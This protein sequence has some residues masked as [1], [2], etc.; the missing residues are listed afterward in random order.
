M[1]R[2]IDLHPDEEGPVATTVVVHVP[3]D[4]PA[5]GGPGRPLRQHP[6][7]VFLAIHGWNDYFYQVELARAV[8][9]AGGR[10][11]AVD[12]RKYGRSLR[13]GQT[14]G[15]IRD[16]ASYDEE[17]HACTDLVYEEHR[18]RLPLVIY[19]HS[20][21]GLVAALWA[22]RHPGA[23]QGLVLNSPWLEYHGATMARQI[24]APV[25]DMLARLSPASV[26]PSGD[27]DFYQRAITAWR[28]PAAGDGDP[29]SADASAAAT[30]RATGAAA[31]GPDPQARGEDSD[32]PFW[33]TGWNPDPAFR[34]G[35]GAPVRAGWLSAILAGHARVSGGLAIDCP[36]LVLTSA[37]SITGETW[38]EGFRA[39]DSVLDVAQI[40]KRVPDLGAHTT[41]VKLEDAVHD[42]TL[43][44]RDVRERAFGEIARFVRAYVLGRNGPETARRFDGV[45]APR[46]DGAREAIDGAWK[47]ETARNG[48]GV[49]A[50]RRVDRAADGEIGG[51][52][53][54]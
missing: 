47:R 54:G 5:M 41:L 22:D 53:S 39:A 30:A 17:I 1:S 11:Y 19:G 40:W 38:T 16:L 27:G 42:V 51:G 46:R 12:L 32:D 52:R 18:G 37:R 48:D 21:G 8:S 26:I 29:D 14:F 9:A 35:T 45:G 50:L 15:F 2:T 10:F 25:V 36:V 44:R 33:T 31:N 4:D 6:D 34:T 28:P 3:E 13:E 20:T 43:S 24:G 7:F 23:A 49:S